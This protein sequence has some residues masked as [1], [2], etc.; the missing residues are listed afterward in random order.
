MAAL[1]PVAYSRA[2]ARTVAAGT[3]VVDSSASGEFSSAPMNAPARTDYPALSVVVPACGP[4]PALG[5]CEAAIRG[6]LGDGD[7]LIVQRTPE[8][9]GPALARNAAA[10]TED[11]FTGRRPRCCLSQCRRRAAARY[12][13][14]PDPQ[15]RQRR[16]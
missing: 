5:E 13:S 15:R 8:G 10:D 4:A 14:D 7:E 1:P 11:T 3:P 16:A 2:A 12:R 9:A 6:R